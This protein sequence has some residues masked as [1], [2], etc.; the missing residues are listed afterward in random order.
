MDFIK[1][2]FMLT[3]CTGLITLPNTP[4]CNCTAHSFRHQPIPPN[5]SPQCA[6]THHFTRAGLKRR[7]I[8]GFVAAVS[9][10][11]FKQIADF[12]SVWNLIVCKICGELR[13]KKNRKQLST[14]DSVE[15]TTLGSLPSI[16]LTMASFDIF[17]WRRRWW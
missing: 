2:Q 8:F 11:W 15:Y 1:K 3:V 13:I 10:I 9:L 14:T 6:D 5:T 16:K 12:F 4:N 17:Y 7:A